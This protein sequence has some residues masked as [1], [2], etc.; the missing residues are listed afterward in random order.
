MQIKLSRLK[1][2]ISEVVEE[3]YA[4]ERM[5]DIMQSSREEEVVEEI[6]PHD[7]AID[8]MIA[9]EIEAA[10]EAFVLGEG[11]EDD[12][13]ALDSPEGDPAP[14]SVDVQQMKSDVQQVIRKLALINTVPEFGELLDIILD[15][16]SAPEVQKKIMT[17]G[18][19]GGLSAQEI[20]KFAQVIKIHREE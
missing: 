18:R 19:Q 4:G 16:F 9:E 15:L 14:D 1:Q 12:L 20:T 6:D 5:D 11:E 10:M 2:I 17:I 8:D 13:A 7:Q 3:K